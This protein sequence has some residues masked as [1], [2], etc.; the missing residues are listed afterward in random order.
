MNDYKEHHR[1]LHEEGE[2]ETSTIKRL[3]MGK[4]AR[5]T[6]PVW[7]NWFSNSLTFFG[8]TYILPTVLSELNQA[9]SGDNN[10]E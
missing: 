7:I 8:L 9:D 1:R 3:F 5:I 4:M 6:V 10:N 2:F